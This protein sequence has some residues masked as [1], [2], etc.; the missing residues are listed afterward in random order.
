[1]PA[2]HIQNNAAPHELLYGIKIMLEISQLGFLLCKI[3]IV[4]NTHI[5]L[6]KIS[7]GFTRIIVDK[8]TINA[9]HYAQSIDVGAALA[10]ENRIK[11]TARW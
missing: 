6:G 3:I 7:F 4:F 11:R 5:K 2:S 8:P 9:A 10:E 1:M